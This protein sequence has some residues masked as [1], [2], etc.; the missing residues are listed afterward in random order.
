MYIAVPLIA[1]LVL[2]VGLVVVWATAQPENGGG[3]D[4][5]PT[6]A[7]GSLGETSAG[8]LTENSNTM[9]PTA[10]AT[11]EAPPTS[12]APSTVSVFSPSADQIFASDET[13]RFAWVWLTVLHDD[14]QFAVYIVS[15]DEPGEAVFVGSAAEPDNASLYVVESSPSELELAAGSYLWQVRLENSQTGQMIVESDLRRILVEEEPTA[16]PTR[17]P[18]T[19]TATP[20]VSPTATEIPPTETATIAVCVPAAPPGWLTHRVELGET[21]SFFSE[22][23]NVPVEEILVANCL[24][25]NAILSVGQQLFIPPPLATDT[26]TPRPTNTP[27]PAPT[28]DSDTGSGGGGGGNDGG[29]GGSRST[30]TPVKP[31]TPEGS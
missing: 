14:E 15:E 1:S 23:A 29:G 6:A 16:T 25:R 22:R 7:V 2:V 28:S 11:R 8:S 21:P 12:S 10:T 20:T 4:P 13:M 19:P 18:P 26:P 5:V 27:A 31:P 30:S 24:S 3:E 17:V 9:T